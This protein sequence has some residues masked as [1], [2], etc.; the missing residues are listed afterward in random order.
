MYAYFATCTFVTFAFTFHFRPEPQQ[1][2]PGG[3]E[4]ICSHNDGR[5][6][7]SS[8]DCRGL[9]GVCDRPSAA[10]GHPRPGGAVPGVSS[11]LIH[12]KI[13]QKLFTLPATQLGTQCKVSSS[14]MLLKK[15]NY[16]GSVKLSSGNQQTTYQPRFVVLIDIGL[17]GCRVLFIAISNISGYR[18]GAILGTT[19][20]EWQAAEVRTSIRDDIGQTDTSRQVSVDSQ[21]RICIY[22]LPC[23]LIFNVIIMT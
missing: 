1:S 9:P 10:G 19:L 18:T 13:S 7:R 5:S 8:E 16:T 6:A 15:E 3:P 12:V 2:G 17:F 14:E 23:T 21:A 22:L 11:L 4:T 20:S